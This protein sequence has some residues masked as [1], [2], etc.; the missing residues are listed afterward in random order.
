MTDGQMM[1]DK[2]I[3]IDRQIRETEKGRKRWQNFTS[4]SEGDH[5]ISFPH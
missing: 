3:N 2:Q 1:T 5:V 4:Y